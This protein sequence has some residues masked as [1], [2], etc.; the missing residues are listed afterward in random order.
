MSLLLIFV[1]SAFDYLLMCLHAV[2]I[3]ARKQ[4]DI[5][6]LVR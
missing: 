4:F 3:I 5:T 6:L 2:Q 1:V